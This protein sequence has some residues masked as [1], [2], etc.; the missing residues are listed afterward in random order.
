M[1]PATLNDALAESRDLNQSGAPVLPPLHDEALKLPAGRWATFWPLAKVNP[2]LDGH[3]LA[4]LATRLHQTSTS[5]KLKA[6]TPKQRIKQRLLAL[7][8]GQRHGLP[9]EMAEQLRELLDRRLEALESAWQK[10]APTT[11]PLHGDFYYGNIVE[12]DSR[13]I[14]CDLDELCHG[15]REVDLATIQ[16]SCR[17]YLKP[18]YWKQFLADHPTDYDRDLL[19]ASVDLQTI[20][21]IIWQAGFWGSRPA[22]RTELQRRLDNINDPNFCWHKTSRPN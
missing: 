10:A 20:G 13:L 19:E 6:W 1:T 8:S 14:L 7:E 2:D 18:D 4:K 17:H 21:V 9:G 15:P 5:T 12:F 22:A 3:K 16:I 11:V